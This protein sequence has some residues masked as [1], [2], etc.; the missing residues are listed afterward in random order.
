MRFFEQRAVVTGDTA[1]HVRIDADAVIGEN[2]EGGDV[3]EQLHVRGAEG[4]RQIGRQRRGDA[5]PSRHIHDGVDADF[6]R[7]F[8][9]GGGWGG[10]PPGGG[11]G[12]GFLIFCLSCWGG[13]GGGRRGG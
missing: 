10:P 11:G 1:N 4:Q 9:G 8:Y 5:E 13:R 3:F 12:G 6:F 7:E 2:G